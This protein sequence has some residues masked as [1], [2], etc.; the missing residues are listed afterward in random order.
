MFGICSLSVLVLD[1]T[2]LVLVLMY[3]SETNLWKEKERFRIRVVQ[4]TT[5]E[6]CLVLGGWIES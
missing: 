3:G 1:E 5:S 2:L 6:V 4:M